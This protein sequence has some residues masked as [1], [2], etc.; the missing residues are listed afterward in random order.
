M[1][2]V[3]L[4]S[5]ALPTSY[6]ADSLTQSGFGPCHFPSVVKVA[7]LPNLMETVLHS[8]H[9]TSFGLPP[10]WNHLHRSILC[11]IY[12]ENWA[13]NGAFLGL[14]RCW[15]EPKNKEDFSAS[16]WE[17]DWA[18]LAALCSDKRDATNSHRKIEASIFPR[19]CFFTVPSEMPDTVPVIIM[20]K[21]ITVGK[22][23]LL[24]SKSH[25]HLDMDITPILET[26]LPLM[27]PYSLSWHG[28]Q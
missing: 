24:A 23:I 6:P 25:L 20:K 10:L 22:H 28:N 9:L 14:G 3:N 17:R 13:W 12:T 5:S 1:V 7:M 19:L 11:S 4:F 21:I 26:Q 16:W 8:F 2:L 18:P 15:M 27:V